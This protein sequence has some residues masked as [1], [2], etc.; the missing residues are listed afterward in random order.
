MTTRIKII[1]DGGSHPVEVRD[2]DGEVVALLEKQGDEFGDSV[3]A[4][5]HFTAQEQG[6]EAGG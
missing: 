3:Y 5:K 6:D 2:A 1:H 4:G